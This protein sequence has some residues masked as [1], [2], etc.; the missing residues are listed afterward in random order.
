MGTETASISIARLLIPSPERRC[1]RCAARSLSLSRYG[2]CTVS[3]PEQSWYHFPYGPSSLLLSSL[4]RALA[5]AQLRHG[6]DGWRRL[7]STTQMVLGS[8]LA[9][10]IPWI[11]LASRSGFLAILGVSPNTSLA[12]LFKHMHS[13]SI[14]FAPLLNG[15]R[16][17]YEEMSSPRP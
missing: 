17:V 8:E 4:G 9:R 12:P 3:S 16:R 14:R 2:P 15:T 10:R 1:N 13:T 7:L 11:L 5:S 6:P